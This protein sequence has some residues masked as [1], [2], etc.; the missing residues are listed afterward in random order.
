MNTLLWI[1]LFALIVIVAK[2]YATIWIATKKVIAPITAG[3]ADRLKILFHDNVVPAGVA[4]PHSIASGIPT[5]KYKSADVKKY[6]TLVM[7]DPDSPTHEAPQFREWRHWVVGNIP[8]KKLQSGFMG[9][10]S[11][12]T[13]YSGPMPREGSGYHRYYFKLYLQPKQ[14]TFE[15]LSGD[16]KNWKSRKFA[17]Q[18]KI[19]KVAQTHFL[20]RRKKNKTTNIVK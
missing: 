13:T 11:T 16:R 6:Y 15:Q 1:V 9:D 19:K 14:L 17:E 3:S 12:I 8:G 7:I 20:T 18:Y 2:Y 5:I 4:I 10:A